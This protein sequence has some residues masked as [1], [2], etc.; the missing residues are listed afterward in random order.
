MIEQ[1]DVEG[2]ME[3]DTDFGYL[4]GLPACFNCEIETCP[5]EPRSW[6]ESNGEEVTVSAR[7]TSLRFGEQVIPRN[8]ALAMF[9]DTTITQWEN[10]IVEELMVC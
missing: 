9:G 7:L 5:A 4:E 10:G 3:A 8:Q 1:L 6:G 2:E